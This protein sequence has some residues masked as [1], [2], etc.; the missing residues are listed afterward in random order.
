LRGSA[1]SPLVGRDEEIDLLLRRWTRAQTGDGQVVLISGE[2]G[3]GKSRSSQ[4]WKS[5]STPSPIFACA[6]SARPITG[7]AH[8]TRSS[9][10]LGENLGSCLMI[11]PRPGSKNSRPCSLARAAPPDEDVAFL[12]DLLSLPVSEQRPLPNLSPHA[13]RNGHWKR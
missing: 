2:P 6:I 5:A 11:R 8:F 1:L 3:I 10:S 13:K 7:T 4:S 12:V 9:T